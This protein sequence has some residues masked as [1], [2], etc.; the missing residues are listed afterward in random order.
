MSVKLIDQ[1][2]RLSL[3][4]RILDGDS[5]ATVELASLYSECGYERMAQNL[6]K[7]TL[8]QAQIHARVLI[9]GSKP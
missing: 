5:A 1:N 2:L 7:V 4:K 6:L 9:E 8:S 3:A